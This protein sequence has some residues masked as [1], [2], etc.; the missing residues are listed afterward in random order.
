[1]GSGTEASCADYPHRYASA[2]KIAY[3]TAG[4]AGTICGNCLQDNAVA[5]ALKRNGHDVVL[6]PAY[7]PVRTDESDV[8]DRRVVFGGIN[9]HLQGHYA[10]FR[11]SGILDRFVDHPRVLRWGFKIRGGYATCQARTDDAG[12]VSRRVW[13][14]ST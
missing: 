12:H 4:A 3:I 8:S 7:T 10:V 11:A 2:L 5:A 1:M 13:T 9:L 14:V 6:L